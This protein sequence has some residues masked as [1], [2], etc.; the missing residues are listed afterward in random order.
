MPVLTEV[1]VSEFREPSPKEDPNIPHQTKALGVRVSISINHGKCLRT[2][3]S[4]F[5]KKLES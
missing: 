2:A 5:H 1:I 3:R 4:N